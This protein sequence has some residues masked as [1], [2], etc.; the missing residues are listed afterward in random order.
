MLNAQPPKKG[1]YAVKT[2][3]TTRMADAIGKAHGID[4]YNVLTGFKFIGETIQKKL[5][6]GNDGFVLGFE[7]S[8]GYLTGGY[9][10]DKDAVI[11][12]TLIC[13]MRCV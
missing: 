5:D 11:A 4:V 8:Y 6:E 1:A 2:S 3:V 7:E 9:V 10:R 13:E 12:S